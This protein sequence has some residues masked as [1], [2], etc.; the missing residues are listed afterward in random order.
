MIG[1]LAVWDWPGADPPILFLHATG[2]HGRLWDQIIQQIPGR[3]CLAPDLRGHGRSA[4]AVPPCHWRT[5]GED[6]IS[7]ID[8]LHLRDVLGVGHSM[9]GQLVVQACAARPAAFAELLLV[10]PTIFVHP[11]YSQTAWNVSYVRRRRNHFKSADEMFHRF[12]SRPPFDGWKPAV[13]H[14]YCDFGLLPAEHGFV[15]ACP[16]DVEASIYEHSHEP[17]ADLYPLLGSIRQP[18]TVMRAGNALS[19]GTLDLAASPTAPDL[20]TRFPHARDIVL[21]DRNHYIPMEAPDLVADAIS[22]RIARNAG[23]ALP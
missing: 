15:L 8:V 18:V 13:L 17:D 20:A 2:F 16:P 22:D 3:R 19:P 1:G 7:L 14:D 4:P 6:I 11:F 5:F 10:D 23:A 12:H 21:P 9:G